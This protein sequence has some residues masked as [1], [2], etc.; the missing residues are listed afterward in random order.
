MKVHRSCKNCNANFTLYQS[1]IRK[2]GGNYCSHRCRGVHTQRSGGFNRKSLTMR[3]RGYV[4]EWAPN[5][6]AQ[7]KGYVPQHRLVMERSLG[8]MLESHE[9]VHHKNEKK[10]DNR[11]ENLA[12]VT[13]AEHMREH[14]TWVSIEGVRLPYGEACKR[15]GIHRSSVLAFRKKTGASHQEAIEHYLRGTA[16]F[17]RRECDIA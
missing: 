16:R 9:L 11:V 10:S 6:P 17:R 7:V 2:G 1:E 4:F 5:H 3:H 15:I 14:G 13:A 8:R 12:V